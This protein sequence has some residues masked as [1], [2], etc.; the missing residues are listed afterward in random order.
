MIENVYWKTF[1]TSL[2]IYI[3]IFSQFGKTDFSME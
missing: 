3:V 1:N 2:G